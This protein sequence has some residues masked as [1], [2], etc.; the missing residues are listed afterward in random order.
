MAA[1]AAAFS[2][3]SLSDD[4]LFSASLFDPVLDAACSVSDGRYTVTFRCASLPYGQDADQTTMIFMLFFGLVLVLL[5]VPPYPVIEELDLV[6]VQF[7]LL[8]EF[9]D[10]WLLV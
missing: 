5:Y 7:E 9:A 3:N 1:A 6:I 10:I 8:L 4:A 2:I